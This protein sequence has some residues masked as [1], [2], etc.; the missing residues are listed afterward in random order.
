MHIISDQVSRK[1]VSSV[2]L[3]D[4]EVM[5]DTG[6]ENISAI[7]Q[8][9]KY[10]V[11][12]LTLANGMVL[13]CADDHI[14]FKGETFEEVFVK[15]L[16][17]KD[18]ILT[19][20][21]TQQVVSVKALGSEEHMFDLTVD[22]V[23]Q[24]YYTNG[25]LSHNTSM[26]Q[27]LSYA[28]YGE[29]I[30][31]IR[32]DNLVNRTNGKGMVVTVEFEVAGKQYK[33]I[34]GRKPNILK[35][36]VGD[37][38]VSSNESQGENKDTQLEIERTLNMSHDMFKQIVCLNTYSTP[39][40]GMRVSEQR[41]IIEQLLGITLLSEKAEALKLEVKTTKD[42][43]QEEDYRI[44]GVVAANEKIQEQINSLVRRK[45]AWDRT[46]DS[47]IKELRGQIALMEQVDI[48]Y[49]MSQHAAL[50]Q[51]QVQRGINELYESLLNRDAAFHSGQDRE[52]AR[53]T[54][55]LN[56]LLK[57]DWQR[58]VDAHLHNQQMLERIEHNKRVDRERSAVNKQISI[59]RSRITELEKNIAL[60]ESHTCYACGSET[61]S[62]E[63][64]ATMTQKQEELANSLTALEAATHH[65]ESLLTDEVLPAL[66]T[67]CSTVLEAQNV[68]A[69]IE[70]LQVKLNAITS[71]PFSE[72]L[73][74][75]EPKVTVLGD[76]PV[77]HY[78]N[79]SDVHSHMASLNALR[80]RLE[81][82][83]TIENPYSVQIEEMRSLALQE[84]SFDEV[85]KLNTLLDHQKFVLDLLTN[86]DSFIRK[87]IIDQNLAHLNSRLSMYLEKIGLPHQVVFMNDLSVEITDFGRELDFYN[88]SRGEMTRLVLALSFAFRDVW[89]SL[90][91]PMSSLFVDE[92]LDSGLDAGGLEGALGI[93]KDMA[94]TR[95][96]SVFLVSHRDELIVR[97][98]HVLTVYKE[99]GFTTYSTE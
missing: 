46:H 43:I 18:T 94:K 83:L 36:F 77:T 21:G 25:I 78:Q 9:V 42:K 31:G 4:W 57:I 97:D 64:Q 23:G 10:Q 22:S 65:S 45:G 93:L 49:E 12:K 54:S 80:S 85:N 84:V 30:N 62:A 71:S 51:Y 50:K 32:K 66:P 76:E 2:D 3:S 74:E 47:T 26:I 52:R 60:M 44:K 19:T 70:F 63:L 92:L 90:Y 14:V 59:L 79:E 29:A 17:P 72:Q 27:G 16:C 81:R 86:K 41:L 91:T 34:R 28:L 73:N 82:E 39:F 7:H 58:D 69:R 48:E 75:L 88:L 61:H 98:D 53:L 96:K 67:I 95:N 99:G 6:W 55:E 5:T 68:P 37:T 38:E 20:A 56:E 87:R 8:T 11:F 13:H 24:R 89:E 1:F 15:S 33:I 35:F 40:L